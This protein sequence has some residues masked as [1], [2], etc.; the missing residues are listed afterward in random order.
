MQTSTSA[1]QR[2]LFWLAG[3]LSFVVPGAGQA[4]RGEA[5]KGFVLALLVLLLNNHR[6]TPLALQGIGW[7]LGLAFLLIALRVFAFVDALVGSRP[8]PNERKAGRWAPC[9]TLVGAYLLVFIGTSFFPGRV[10]T[11]Y[12][13][14]ES[15]APTI[16]KGDYVVADLNA[17]QSRAPEAG[18]LAFFL[19]PRD[20]TILYVKRV[21]AVPGDTLQVVQK[22]VLLNGKALPTEPSQETKL[23]AQ[24]ENEEDRKTLVPHAETTPHGTHAVLLNPASSLNESFGPVTLPEGKFFTLGDN[25]DRSSDSR[26]WGEVSREQLVGKPA[27]VYFSLDEATL[28]IRWDRIGRDLR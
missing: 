28:Q 3:F 26:I 20:Q 7:M 22:K 9:V 21:M 13:P 12:V 5:K 14:A 10:K 15:M 17:F 8:S 24:L 2:K 1:R 27:Y 6:F 25:R 23:A 16:R 18:E 11:F 19:Y 4:Y